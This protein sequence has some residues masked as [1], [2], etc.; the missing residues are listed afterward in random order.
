[1]LWKVVAL[2]YYPALYYPLLACQSV[3]RA[4][5]Y[6]VG[7]VLSWLHCGALIWQKAECPQTRQFYRYYSLLSV[8]PQIGC[9]L[10]LGVLYPALL[11]RSLCQPPCTDQVM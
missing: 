6:L 5:G 3:Q 8:L 11:L 10:L 7:S 4:P 2:F 9:L 1:E